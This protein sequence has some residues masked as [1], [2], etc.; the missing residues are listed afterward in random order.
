M[1]L[2]VYKIFFYMES[3]E[4]KCLPES[5]WALVRKSREIEFS[6]QMIKEN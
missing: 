2:V 6:E 4:I 1:H 3:S 5:H